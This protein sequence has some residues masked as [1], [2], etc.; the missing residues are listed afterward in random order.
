M[1][2]V[3]QI[4]QAYAIYGYE[5]EVLAASIRHPMH[6]VQAIE[7]GADVATI[8][9]DVIKKLLLH[10]LTDSGLAKFSADAEAL[11]KL[12]AAPAGDGASA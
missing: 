6:V 9:L 3:Q 2:L 5:T 11:A 4:V 7:A 10:P 12:I 8:P 1:M